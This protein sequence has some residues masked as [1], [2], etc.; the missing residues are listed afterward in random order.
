MPVQLRT[1]SPWHSPGT[2]TSPGAPRGC[3]SDPATAFGPIATVLG[4]ADFTAVNLETA[5]TSRGHAAAEDLPL[6]HPASGLHRDPRRRDRPG[7]DGQQ[8][9]PRLRPGGPGGHAGGGPGAPAS[10]TW[11][12]GST[13][14]RRG[15]PYMTTIKGV[16]D[17]GHR[18]IPGRRLASSWV[19]TRH[20]PGEAN[21]INLRPHA[22][23]G[24][25]RQAARRSRHRVH[26]LG[27]RGPGVPRPEPAVTGAASWPRQEPA[28][29]SARTPTCCRDPAGSATRS[30]PTAWATSCGGST[31][32]APPPVS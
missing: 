15:R 23:R 8:P 16:Q 18:G 13:P 19:A 32:T 1:A 29:S 11:G 5:V 24:P 22:R 3:C 12:S 28:S 14:P 30:W 6:P 17:R 9:R 26:A 20:R 7:H 21:S 2:S 4:S 31:L 10:R 27:H 25:G